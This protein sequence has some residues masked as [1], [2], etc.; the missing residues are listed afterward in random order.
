[1]IN[2]TMSKNERKKREAINRDPTTKPK[3]RVNPP[4]ISIMFLLFLSSFICAEDEIPKYHCQKNTSTSRFLS[5]F[6]PFPSSMCT[7]VERVE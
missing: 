5:G 2:N 1:M 6:Y 3:T 7:L 4:I